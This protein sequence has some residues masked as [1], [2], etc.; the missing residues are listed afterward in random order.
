MTRLEPILEPRKRWGQ[1]WSLAVTP[2]SLPRVFYVQG[3]QEP[4]IYNRTL[5]AMY[6]QNSVSAFTRYT[7][8]KG[9]C[10]HVYIY[11]YMYFPAPV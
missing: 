2:S 1:R 5:R 4:S 8:G 6:S 7:D 11:I 9:I 3:S 10:I